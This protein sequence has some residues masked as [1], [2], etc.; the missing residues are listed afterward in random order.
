MTGLP[1]ITNLKKDSYDSIL[2]IFDFLTKMVYYKPIKITIDGLKL[3]KIVIN[4]II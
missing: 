2:I 3:A 4:V 1:I